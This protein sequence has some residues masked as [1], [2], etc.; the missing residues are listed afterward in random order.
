MI[1]HL[2]SMRMCGKSFKNFNHT[3]CM[4]SA[5]KVQETKFLAHYKTR[6]FDFEP[7]LL[8]FLHYRIFCVFLKEMKWNFIVKERGK[9][10][11]DTSSL[12]RTD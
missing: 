5:F 7:S 8:N 11:R 2:T 9:Q 4:K 12:A 10:M 3:N 6:L 1:S